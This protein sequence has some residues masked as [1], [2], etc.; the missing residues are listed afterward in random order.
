MAYVDPIFYLP[1][2][3][4]ANILMFADHLGLIKLTPTVE[5]EQELCQDVS[6]IEAGFDSLFLDV[7]A[8]KCKYL[9][10]SLTPAPPADL[11][12]PPSVRGSTLIRVDSLKYL[13]TLL[14]R[15]LAF[16]VN[17][18]ALATKAKRILGVLH[19]S[20]GRF[21]GQERFRALYVG[22]I[23]PIITY[24]ITVTFP[25]YQ[26]DWSLLEKVNR[27]GCRLITNDYKKSYIDLLAKTRL[28]SIA[29]I[30]LKRGLR[31]L[32]KYVFGQRLLP[33]VLQ[34]VQ[35]VRGPVRRS[36]RLSQDHEYSLM[37]P[38]SGVTART[39]Q[40]VP[41]YKL[42]QFWNVL[43]SA[44]NFT[45]DIFAQLGSFTTNVKSIQC[46]NLILVAF[47]TCFRMSPKCNF[48]VV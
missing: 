35:D 18:K 32:Y 30:S 20:V 9:I 33:G 1:L 46:L 11:V 3:L 34:R 17:A 45:M 22:K 5:A 16:D 47:P 25:R 28:P 19:R 14:D 43:S 44:P 29:Q 10:C 4:G 31:L 48:Y 42:I 36:Q 7:A 21:A 15:R 26:K 8:P 38:N 2:S 37:V 39:G 40:L 24:A 13:G 12:Y 23:L 6:V 41:I 27:Y